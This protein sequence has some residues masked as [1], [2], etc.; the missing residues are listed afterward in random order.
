MY[1]RGKSMKDYLSDAGG[2]TQLGKKNKA[3]VVYA[4]GRSAKI[5]K[6]LGIFNRYPSIEPGSNIFVPQ[7]PK[8]EGQFDA[9]KAGIF[10]SAITALI[11]AISL[12]RR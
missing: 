9:A 6:T 1:E 10:I 2:V 5:K 3:F 8:K 7:K 11:T 4:N 12:F